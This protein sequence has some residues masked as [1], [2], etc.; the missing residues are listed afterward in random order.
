MYTGLMNPV[1]TGPESGSNQR[2]ELPD[3]LREDATH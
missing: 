3:Y 1:M 2:R